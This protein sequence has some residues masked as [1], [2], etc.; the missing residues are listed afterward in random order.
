MRIIGRL[1]HPQMQITVF[2]NDGRFP[3]QFE[4]LGQTQQYRFRHGPAL[5]NLGDIEQIIDDR[6]KE[7]VMAIFS[8][9]RST[10]TRVVKDHLSEVPTD[11]LPDII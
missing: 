6:F 4:L 11:D 8:D 9:M 5:K 1:P 2:S 7:E 10:Q 3:V